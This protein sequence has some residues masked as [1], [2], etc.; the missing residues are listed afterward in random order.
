MDPRIRTAIHEAAREHGQS[1]ALARRLIG[2]FTAVASGAEDIHDLDA[3]RRHLDL[4]YKEVRLEPEGS[5]N[6][7]GDAPGSNAE[8]AAASAGLDS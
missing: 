1:S 8:G 5:P 7:S 2:W 4:A 6:E 3:S